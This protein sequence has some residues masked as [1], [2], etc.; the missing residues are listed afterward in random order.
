[1]VNDFLDCLANIEVQFQKVGPKI[2]L[3][4]LTGSMVQ[5]QDL[6]EDI[7]TIPKYQICLIQRIL[8]LIFP[9]ETKTIRILFYTIS[10]F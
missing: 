6:A 8:K 5:T 1:M 9:T 7:H 3:V 4:V 2:T 10:I